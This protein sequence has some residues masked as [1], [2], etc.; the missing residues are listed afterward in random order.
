MVTPHPSGDPPRG[1]PAPSCGVVRKPPGRRTN[2]RR[3]A[4]LSARAGTAVGLRPPSAFARP[5][6]RSRQPAGRAALLGIGPLPRKKCPGNCRIRPGSI[7]FPG[8]TASA[9][10]WA[11][12]LVDWCPI[13]P[14][15]GRIRGVRPKC[16]QSNRWHGDPPCGGSESMLPRH[17]RR[18]IRYR[19]IARLGRAKAAIRRSRLA[20]A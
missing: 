15:E 18:R 12:T 5:K 11:S 14:A 8:H 6:Y 13:C 4:S 10:N 1:R 19:R 16:V 9:T 7:R 20:A 17:R 3:P 2:S